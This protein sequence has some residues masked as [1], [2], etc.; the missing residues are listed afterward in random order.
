MMG[1]VLGIKVGSTWNIGLSA[2][3]GLS[4]DKIKHTT[5]A[6]DNN[7]LYLT[8]PQFMYSFYIENGTSRHKKV[9]GGCRGGIFFSQILQLCFSAPGSGTLMEEEQSDEIVN[10]A[11]SR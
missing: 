9:R 11:I 2:L 3:F 4:K 6:L 7:I 5:Q 10:P 1:P 8:I